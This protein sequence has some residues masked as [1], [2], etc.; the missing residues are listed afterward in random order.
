[1]VINNTPFISIYTDP[2]NSTNKFKNSVFLGRVSIWLF[3]RKNCLIIDRPIM[4]KMDTLKFKLAGKKEH[5]IKLVLREPW[6]LRVNDFVIF[7]STGEVGGRCNLA[8]DCYGTSGSIS[9]SDF[10][11]IFRVNCSL[12]DT[13][14]ESVVP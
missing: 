1:L 12:T 14:Q 3:P 7:V 13:S 6:A 5:P 2:A 8:M 4:A 10:P 11:M 9:I